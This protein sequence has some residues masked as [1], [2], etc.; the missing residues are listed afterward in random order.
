MPAETVTGGPT[1]NGKAA[2]WTGASRVAE[3]RVLVTGENTQ[4]LP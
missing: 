4:V 2:R 3:Y 1:V